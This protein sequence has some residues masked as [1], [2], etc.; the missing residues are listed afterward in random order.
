MHILRDGVINGQS[1]V[2]RSYPNVPCPVLNNGPDFIGGQEAVARVQVGFITGIQ[3]IHLQ[4]MIC[5]D[6]YVPFIVFKKSEY[7]GTTYIDITLRIV[8]L[9]SHLAFI[10]NVKDKVPKMLTKSVQ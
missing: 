3:V 4:A 5:S 8:L 9:D 2:E 6:P 1:L 7:N 10:L